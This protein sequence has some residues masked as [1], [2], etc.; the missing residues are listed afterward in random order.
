MAHQ[1]QAGF[2]AWEVSRRQAVP[3]M[4]GFSSQ[5]A[6]GLPALEAV[7][8]CAFRHL[9]TRRAVETATSLLARTP[10]IVAARVA[11]RAGAGPACQ[12][13]ELVLA[14]SSP[15]AVHLAPQALVETPPMAVS[16][17][18]PVG[19]PSNT[20]AHLRPAPRSAVVDCLAT[21]RYALAAPP[22]HSAQ[23]E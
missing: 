19:L 21:S 16:P 5:V 12:H 13:R 7:A 8:L 22:T 11:A 3:P 15:L 6:V 9:V 2:L 18:S 14:E 10:A 4:V 20:G 17:V 23:M 1:A